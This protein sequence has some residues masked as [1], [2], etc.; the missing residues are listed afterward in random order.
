M[1]AFYGKKIRD[2][3]NVHLKKVPLYWRKVTEKW[4]EEHPEG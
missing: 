2:G 1:G 4:L 3:E